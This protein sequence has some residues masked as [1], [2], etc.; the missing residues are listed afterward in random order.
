[1]TTRSAAAVV[2][3][4]PIASAVTDVLAAAVLS[5]AAPVPGLGIRGKQN[6]RERRGENTEEQSIS[7]HFRD[8][9]RVMRQ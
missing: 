2:A 9:F 1:L 7:K 6:Q 8:S 5:A 4:A 3:N